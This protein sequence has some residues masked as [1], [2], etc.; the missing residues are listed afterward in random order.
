MHSNTAVHMDTAM[1]EEDMVILTRRIHIR[2]IPATVFTMERVVSVFTAMPRLQC[3]NVISEFQ[4]FF[5]T[6]IITVTRMT[7][8]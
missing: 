7:Q 2:T 8:A 6:T 5:W 3:D 1:A 4:Q